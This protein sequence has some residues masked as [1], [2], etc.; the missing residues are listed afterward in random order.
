MPNLPQFDIPTATVAPNGNA[1]DQFGNPV[2]PNFGKPPANI[3]LD[4]LQQVQMQSILAGTGIDPENAGATLQSL[5]QGNDDVFLS[6][7]AP[8]I[9]AA[10]HALL[11]NPVTRGVGTVLDD[12]G[13]A[14]KGD[15]EASLFW[16]TGQPQLAAQQLAATTSDIIPSVKQWLDKQNV[17]TSDPYEDAR[18]TLPAPERFASGIGPELLQTAPQMALT[19]LQPELG[20]L[21]FGFTPQGFDPV[22]AGVALIAPEGGKWVGGV[23]EKLA[24]KAGI[25]NAD[26]LGIVNRLGGGA[27]VAGL[28]SAPALYQIAQMNPG[29]ER[30]DA[31]QEAASNAILTGFLGGL[32]PHDASQAMPDNETAN[33][34][35]NF[36][37]AP[38]SDETF[39]DGIPRGSQDTTVSSAP[40]APK[41]S[42]PRFGVA[43]SASG[44]VAAIPEAAE[45]HYVL[46]PGSDGG[47]DDKTTQAG[48]N[49]YFR[50]QKNAPPVQIVNEPGWTYNGYGVRGTVQDGRIV[51]RAFIDNPDTLQNVLGKEHSHLLL[52]SNQ[53]RGFI[54][55]LAASDLGDDQYSALAKQYPR[56]PDEPT[57]DWKARLTDEFIVR[58]ARKNFPI[59]NQIV[60][61]VKTWLAGKGIG[62]LTDKEAAR[63]ILRA[64]TSDETAAKNVEAINQFPG[65]NELPSPMRVPLDRIPSKG[66]EITTKRRSSRSQTRVSTTEFPGRTQQNSLMKVKFP[67]F[68]VEDQSIVNTLD[69]SIHPA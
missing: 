51:N 37:S 15:A 31:I 39:A 33:A 63:A 4:P 24:A 41:I 68:A 46:G 69:V 56:Q 2:L 3:K 57:S 45:P 61:R 59:W 12:A 55:Y 16:N 60:G 43:G 17:D 64:S 50:R 40:L 35:Q 22:Q 38:T 47:L 67:E 25:S 13:K 20:A 23:A 48:V 6:S 65:T 28:L 10:P 27:G 53:G 5:L 29:P 30:N 44:P 66:A 11:D 26:A 58:A 32:G 1:F 8:Y 49:N 62:Q 34:P 14:V 54:R 9:T 21:S 7:V 36:L 19:A 52:S 18:Q 42:Q